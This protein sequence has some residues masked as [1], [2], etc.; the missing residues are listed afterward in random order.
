MPPRLADWSTVEVDVELSRDY[1]PAAARVAGMDLGRHR[2]TGSWGPVAA[3]LHRMGARHVRVLEPV[4]LCADTDAASAR[5]LVLIRELTARGL[6]VEWVARCRD[7]CVGEGLFHHLYPP[8]RIE[9][10]VAGSTL[11]TWR[12]TYFPCRCVSRRGPGFVEIRDRRSG[13]LEVITIDEPE[14]LTAIAA[15]VEGVA[16]GEVPPKVREELTDARLVAEQAGHLWWLP[17]PAHRWPFPALI[18]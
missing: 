8:V 18:V 1:D 2:L 15:M 3:D 13:S 16:A 14:H 7:G 4:D 12:D 9:D 10:P 11:P 17:T 6:A 5:A